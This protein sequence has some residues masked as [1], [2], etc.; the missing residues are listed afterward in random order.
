MLLNL[1]K[2]IDEKIPNI[3]SEILSE[4]PKISGHLHIKFKNIYGRKIDMVH[5]CRKNEQ[6]FL[7]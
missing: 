1:T 3:H 2:I 6:T 5:H 7:L 4:I